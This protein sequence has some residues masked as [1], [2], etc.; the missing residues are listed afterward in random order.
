MHN[1]L[2]IAKHYKRL[3]CGCG[4]FLNLLMF[5]TVRV[6]HCVHFDVFFFAQKTFQGSGNNRKSYYVCNAKVTQSKFIVNILCRYNYSP[7]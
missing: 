4:L 1:V 2:K 7:V 3:R 6:S 5:S